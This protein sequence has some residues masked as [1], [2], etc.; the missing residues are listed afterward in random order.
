MDLKQTKL[1]YLSLLEELRLQA[2]SIENS[3]IHRA[4]LQRVQC[5]IL[6][7]GLWNHHVKG[8]KTLLLKQLPTNILVKDLKLNITRLLVNITT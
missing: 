1:G 5:M 4:R 3:V 6:M 8:F 7:L 2:D